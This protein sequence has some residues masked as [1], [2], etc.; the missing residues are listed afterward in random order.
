M[1][2]HFTL[3]LVAILASVETPNGIPAKPGPAGDTGRWQLTP[4][5]RH[6]RAVDLRRI[7]KPI[8]DENLAIAHVVWI[9]HVLLKNH[10]TPT[11][12]TVA[13]AWNAGIGAE[14]R[15]TAPARA[16]DFARRVANLVESSP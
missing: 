8:T 3:L 6:D 2:T 16:R 4:A 12:Y 15:G 13:L 7:G 14:L 10:I 1:T 5:V 9:E 11:P